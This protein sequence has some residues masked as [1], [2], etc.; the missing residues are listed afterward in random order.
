MIRQF[1]KQTFG[2]FLV[3]PGGTGLFGCDPSQFL[4][5]VFGLIGSGRRA[6][7]RSLVYNLISDFFSKFLADKWN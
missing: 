6:D 7:S 5:F 3:E 1:K 4:T 2:F